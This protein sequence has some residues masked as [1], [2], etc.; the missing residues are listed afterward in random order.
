MHGDSALSV[1]IGTSLDSDSSFHST[2]LAL[3]W[4]YIAL[5]M[6]QQLIHGFYLLSNG[7]CI[8]VAHYKNWLNSLSN[9]LSVKRNLSLLQSDIHWNR[10]ASKLFIFGRRLG[11]FI[12]NK[13]IKKA[14]VYFNE[15]GDKCDEI[16]KGQFSKITETACLSAGS[17]KQT[18]AR[19]V[20]YVTR[21]WNW[22]E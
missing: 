18:I 19:T 10:A 9:K 2:F 4:Q 16:A 3:N 21:H 12:L 6:V 15:S 1:P 8:P 11:K 20:V 7:F 17:S 22:N 13:H 5:A 14:K